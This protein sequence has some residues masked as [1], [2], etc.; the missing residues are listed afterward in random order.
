MERPKVPPCETR[1]TR[2]VRTSLS[3]TGEWK[4]S[5]F[6]T[7]GDQTATSPRRTRRRKQTKHDLCDEKREIYRIQMLVDRKT[8]EMKRIQNHRAKA[9][10]NYEKEL[11]RIDELSDEYKKALIQIEVA[12]AREKRLA[13]R[14]SGDKTEKSKMY[15]K[16]M[17]DVHHLRYEIVKHEAEKE[18]L[19]QYAEFLRLFCPKGKELMEFYTKPDVLVEELHRME[20]ENLYIIQHCQ[21]IEDIAAIR[22]KP[23]ADQCEEVKTMQ[24]E[25]DELMKELKEVGEFIGK[26]DL[27]QKK[28]IEAEYRELT[29]LV[30]GTFFRCFKVRSNL[31]PLFML[32]KLQLEMERMYR[33]EDKVE[34]EF[35]EMKR[36]AQYRAWRE[37]QRKKKLEEQAAA[38]NRKIQQTLA[39]ASKPI[40]YK[41]KRPV[42]ERM[43]PFKEIRR[44]DEEAIRR[45]IQE[46]KE[47]QLLFGEL[48]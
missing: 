17:H 42:V 23:C 2:L 15:E 43:V 20:R 18:E 30:H 22:S 44:E 27:T 29:Q 28:E 41:W 9:E 4:T 13:D 8:R 46:E 34:P 35:L 10:Q 39:R 12:V 26:L 38:Q 6:M 37:S 11:R 40:F 19:S 25:A 21:H 16:H 33:L 31:E 36:T 5:A 24:A 47:R 48:E 7:T 45:R 3:K 14:A 32:E 1:A